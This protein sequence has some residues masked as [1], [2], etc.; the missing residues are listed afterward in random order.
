MLS[1]YGVLV[2]AIR[3]R[4]QS[5]KANHGQS[6]FE[7][8]FIKPKH[9]WATLFYYGVLVYAKASFSS[10]NEI[11]FI[12][13]DSKRQ[14][15]FPYVV[16]SQNIPK[17]SS[18]KEVPLAQ[19]IKSI[20]RENRADIRHRKIVESNKE[21]GLAIENEE[22]KFEDGFEDNNITDNNSHVMTSSTQVNLVDYRN[23]R[24]RED[25]S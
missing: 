24:P 12:V 8:K 13:P 17:R 5:L 15:L 18:D 11:M 7:K 9:G 19:K 25:W 4:H 6:T 22:T 10:D 2:P 23:Y 3:L 1:R 21:L 16:P 20:A 14:K